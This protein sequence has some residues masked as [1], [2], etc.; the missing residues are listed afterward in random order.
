[1]VVLSISIA[2]LAIAFGMFVSR[3]YT[4]FAVPALNESLSFLPSRQFDQVRRYVEME[5][6]E[7]LASPSTSTLFRRSCGCPTMAALA[8]SSCKSV[9]LSPDIRRRIAIVSILV[10]SVLICG[11]S[12]AC[13]GEG[14]PDRE[15]IA[16]WVERRVEAATHVFLARITRVRRSG[17]I[18]A[19][20]TTAEFE[21]LEMLKGVPRFSVLGISERQNFGLQED[22]VRVLFVTDEGMILP[23]SDYRHFMSNDQ[24][25]ALLRER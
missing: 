9:Q 2:V 14:V 20:D 24:L 1:M 5:E 23:Y 21:V 22:D 7:P 8:G 18:P 17:K 3:L 6:H 16:Q 15:E 10:L 12:Q 13:V 11:A 25:L 4:G 19:L